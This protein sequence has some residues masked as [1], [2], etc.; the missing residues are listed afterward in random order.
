[1]DVCKY[2]KKVVRTGRLC[3]AWTSADFCFF[4]GLP[5]G[6]GMLL[7]PS[8]WLPLGMG[9]WPWVCVTLFQSPTL[10]ILGDT[11][12]YTYTPGTQ[13]HKH[14]LRSALFKPFCSGC[15]CF[16][17]SDNV[18]FFFVFSFVSNVFYNDNLILPLF[19]FVLRK[20]L[21][22]VVVVVLSCPGLPSL[23][24][25]PCPLLYFPVFFLCSVSTF[26]SLVPLFNLDS[27]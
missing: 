16:F 19:L 24:P 10:S 5:Q 14:T 21:Q 7:M 8:A 22:F 25:H 11:I 3:P 15:C 20:F 12:S 6:Q 27:K 13:T 26:P 4:M 9:V 17:F 18:G 1:M 2:K 23:T